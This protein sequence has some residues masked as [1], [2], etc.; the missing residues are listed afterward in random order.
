MKTV[1]ITGASR[2]IGR[3]VAR[4]F[5]NK[6]W[7]VGLYSTNASALAE[8][9]A[10]IGIERSCFQ[11]CDV[12]DRASVEAAMAHFAAHTDGRMDVLVNNA[13]VLSS[14]SFESLDFDDYERIIDINIKGMTRVAQAAFPLLKQTPGAAMVN[15][16]SASSIHGVPLLAVYSASKYYVNGLTEALNIEWKAHDIR[17]TSV[18]PP[19]VKTG[20][21][22]DLAAQLR[23]RLTFDLAPQTVAQAV[24][25]AA[26]GRRVDYIL[27]P[28]ALVWGWSDKYLPWF[29]R[30][31]LMSWLAGY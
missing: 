9:R 6:G 29:G 20:M 8:L 7:Y 10:E 4:L 25:D 5:A 21:A 11:V 2:G 24:Y 14:G 12:T 19:V 31:K 22:D 16:C 30:R 15:L 1:F 3:E 18:K 28:K 27:T 13:G 26:G 23:K 17:V